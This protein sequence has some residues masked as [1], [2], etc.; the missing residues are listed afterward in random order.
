M[1][2]IILILVLFV[3]TMNVSAQYRRS[4][5][6]EFRLGITTGLNFSNMNIKE[7]GKNTDNNYSAKTGFKIGAI[8]EYAFNDYFALSP[9]LIFTQR[10]FKEKVSESYY[11]MTMSGEAKMNINYF[12]LPVHAVV[13][14][15]INK[16]LKIKGIVGPYFGYA[17]SGKIK[18]E[19]TIK[20]S[21]M[22]TSADSE[23]KLKFGSGEDEVNPFDIGL[24]IGAGIEFSSFFFRL[25][26]DFGF[27]NLSN[28]DYSTVKNRNFG[29]SIGYLFSFN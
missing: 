26:Y 10:G 8:A 16:N 21:G 17:F 12:Q 18:S 15:P 25:Q 13:M 11:G 24:T 19:A 14:Y 23:E 7:D 22:S 5:N 9:E 29:L 20:G 6:G 4:S 27:G 3:I 1:K 2:K 28:D